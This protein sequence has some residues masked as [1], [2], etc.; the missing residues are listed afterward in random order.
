MKKTPRIG[1][2][3][4]W[5]LGCV[6]SASWSTLKHKVTAFDKD[7]ALIKDLSKGVP[8]IFEPDLAETLVK[9]VKNKSLSFT[10]GLSGLRACDFVFLAYD[11][12]VLEDDRSDLTLLENAVQDLGDVLKDGAVVIVSSQT[13]AGTAAGFRKSLKAF[14][15]SCAFPLVMRQA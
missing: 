10:S 5:H 6:I 8:P 12:P 14:F 2:F 9:N 13:P 3:G 1:V 15:N 11:T 7:D 4:L